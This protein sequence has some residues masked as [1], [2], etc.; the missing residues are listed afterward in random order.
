[1]NLRSVFTSPETRIALHDWLSLSQ[2]SEIRNGLRLS[3]Y[4]LSHTMESS[5]GVIVRDTNELPLISRYI[6]YRNV[7]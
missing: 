2:W 6:K 4:I 3:S 1:M 7:V 5:L